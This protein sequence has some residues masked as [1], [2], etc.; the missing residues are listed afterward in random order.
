MTQLAAKFSS[1]RLIIVCV[2]IALVTP[3]IVVKYTPERYWNGI[4]EYGAGLGVETGIVSGVQLVVDYFRK[5]PPRA[6]V[7]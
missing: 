1:H 6:V 2:I 5:H 3:A 4:K 7:R